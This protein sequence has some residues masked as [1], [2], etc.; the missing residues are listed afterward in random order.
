MTTHGDTHSDEAP[1]QKGASRGSSAVF[2]MKGAADMEGVSV[3]TF[4][5]R[6]AELKRWGHHRP[7]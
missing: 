5:Q 7:R 6:R 1:S 2:T 4:H 3:N